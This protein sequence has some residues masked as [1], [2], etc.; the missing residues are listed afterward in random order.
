M[1]AANMSGSVLGLYEVVLSAVALSLRP[2]AVLQR[3]KQRVLH[4]SS[5]IYVQHSE[6]QVLTGSAD[7]S[8]CTM[9]LI[10]QSVAGESGEL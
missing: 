9:L 1:P 4:E 10:A 3:G 2:T 6:L 7:V 8:V 5:L